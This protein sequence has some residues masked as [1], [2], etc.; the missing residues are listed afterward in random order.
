MDAR[1]LVGK[2]VVV[3]RALKQARELARQLEERGAEVLLLPMVTFASPGGEDREHLHKALRDLAGFDAVL[4][5]SAYAVTCMRKFSQQLGVNRGLQDSVDR[6]VAA[7]GPATAKELESSGL[8]V[9]YIAKGGTAESLAR[10]LGIA[11]AGRKV[12]LPRSNLGDARLSDALRAS[13]AHVTEVVAYVTDM[14]EAPDETVL[15]RIRRGDVDV[16]TFASPSAFNNLRRFIDAG[17]LAKLAARV[18]FAAIGPTTA[19]AIRKAGIPVDIQAT[20]SST[21]G[22]VD[23]IASYFQGSTAAVRRP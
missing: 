7:V 9:D 6:F 14:P 11:L 15:D 5:L 22:L 18:P 20:Q 8:R 23:A 13:G 4:F 1:S 17:K 2:R 10:E 21:E 12:L 19:G 3:T 16:L